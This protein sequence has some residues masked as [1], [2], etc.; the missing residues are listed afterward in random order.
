[1]TN[2]KYFEVTIEAWCETNDGMNVAWVSAQGIDQNGQPA[3]VKMSRKLAALDLHIGDTVCGMAR[4][5]DAV[6]ADKGLLV[7]CVNVNMTAG[8]ERGQ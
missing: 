7:D 8:I 6:K 1:M 2:R 4:V 5:T 3:K